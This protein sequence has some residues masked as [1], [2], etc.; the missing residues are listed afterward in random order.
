MYK[1][2]I[3]MTK[4]EQ[5]QERIRILEATVMFL[6]DNSSDYFHWACKAKFCLKHGYLRKKCPTC[7]AAYR[8]KMAKNNVGSAGSLVQG[9]KPGSSAKGDTTQG[10]DGHLYQY[11]PDPAAESPGWDPP[12]PTFLTRIDV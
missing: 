11:R 4:L 1:T 9:D 10:R 3:K 7:G 12:N 6:W 2:G 8:K 5:L